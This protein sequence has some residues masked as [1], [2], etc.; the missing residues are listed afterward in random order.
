MGEK[1]RS[2][3]PGAAHPVAG[4][5]KDETN[6]EIF[7]GEGGI[8]RKHEARTTTTADTRVTRIPDTVRI[9]VLGLRIRLLLAIAAA[10]AKA[11]RASWA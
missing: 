7:G 6:E 8:S 3:R 10:S 5:S 2:T 1:E 9:P 4:E 11:S